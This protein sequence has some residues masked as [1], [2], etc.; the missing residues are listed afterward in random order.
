M[1]YCIGII[2]TLGK[3]VIVETDETGEE[4]LEK[5]IYRVVKAYDDQEIVLCADDILPN[6][7]TGERVYFGEAGWIDPEEVM[8]KEADFT[9]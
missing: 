8:Q 2:E 3:T 9:L 4:G 7:R 6:P 5:A 1:K